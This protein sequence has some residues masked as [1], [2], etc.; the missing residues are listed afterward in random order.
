MLVRDRLRYNLL[1]CHMA[2]FAAY[3]AYLRGSLL[4]RLRLA[5]VD[6]CLRACVFAWVLACSLA[7]CLRRFM[8]ACLCACLAPC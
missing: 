1:G 4:A 2:P 5:C 6:S 7:S 8:L 3:V